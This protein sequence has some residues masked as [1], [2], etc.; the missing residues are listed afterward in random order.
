M[1][2]NSK[3][4]WDERYFAKEYA[5][6]TEPNRF[7]KEQLDKLNPGKLLLPGEGEGRNAVYAAKK[8]WDVDA[9]D[10]SEQ[11]R[12]K[13]L[14]LAAKENVNINYTV[15][16]FEN[17]IPPK[18]EY[19]AIGIVFVHL[20]KFER[21]KLFLRLIDALKDNGV[22][23]MEVFSTRQ[24]GRD[25]GG[26]KSENFLYQFEDVKNYFDKLNTIIIEES[27]IQLSEGVLHKGE[28]VVLRYVG[29]KPVK[30]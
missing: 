26:P 17:Y 24:L 19:D 21:E 27:I 5:Y 30:Y 15:A 20:D 8:N 23:I 18:N 7:F 13:A 10:F 25:S 29:R 11:G 14:K 1:S 22:I 4:S 28:A 3:Q 16:G 2:S 6:G 9:V 12:L